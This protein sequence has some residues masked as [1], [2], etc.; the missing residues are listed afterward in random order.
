MVGLCPVSVFGGSAVVDHCPISVVGGCGVLD[1]CPI[2]VFFVDLLW[3]ITVCPIF[4]LC[5]SVV[6]HVFGGSAVADHCL[7]YFWFRWIC[8]GSLLV[9]F[10]CLVG[11]LWRITFYFWLGG[12]VVDHGLCLVDLLWWIT[13]CPISGL[14]G[15]VVDHGFQPIITS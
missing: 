10:M 12:P 7:S 13:V 3:W 15:P 1:H 11:L 4:V 9:L 8:G 2:S 14:G 6:D 5:G